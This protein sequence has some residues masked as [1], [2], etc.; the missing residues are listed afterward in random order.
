MK[1]ILTKFASRKFLLALGTAITLVASKQYNAAVG[2]VLAYLGVEGVADIRGAG[3]DQYI[4]QVAEPTDAVSNPLGFAKPDPKQG[5][6][7]VA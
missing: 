2:V 7:E 4:E 1:D 3:A 5:T 6:G